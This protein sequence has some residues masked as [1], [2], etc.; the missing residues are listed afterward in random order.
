MAPSQWRVVGAG[1]PRTGT[2]STREALQILLKEPCYH[3]T[4]CA[5]NREHIAFWQAVHDKGPDVTPQMLTR[6]FDDHLEFVAG[7]D[8][9]VSKYYKLFM[10]AYPDAKV[11]L[12]VRDPVTWYTSVRNTI[13]ALNQ[14]QFFFPYKYT[15][16]LVGLQKFFEMSIGLCEQM[17][18]VTVHEKTS[19]KA[20]KFYNDWVE[21][22][23]STVPAEKLLVF[24]VKDGWG[25]LCKF[26]DVPVP[27]EPFP[28][29]NDTASMQKLMFRIKLVSWLSVGF[30][31]VGA[32]AG[33]YAASR[34]NWAAV[35]NS[36]YT[37]GLSFVD[38][39]I[40]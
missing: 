8:Y 31:S 19:E 23:K 33:V 40:V 11:V 32:V 30:V 18:A 25:P 15:L 26:L 5:N 34:Y 20:V 29:V 37:N 22:V 16:R 35:C 6:F 4:C 24:S 9:P 38:K 10:E 2:L 27:S 39:F 36:L 14:L 21:D 1:L 17:F 13:G 28:N 7:V 3:M 12:T